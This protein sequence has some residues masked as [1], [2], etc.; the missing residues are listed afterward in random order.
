MEL[1]ARETGLIFF[2]FHCRRRRRCVLLL[3]HCLISSVIYE[4][5][6]W[7]MRRRDARA[8]AD[9]ALRRDAEAHTDL[10]SR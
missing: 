10:S 4:R 7:A 3:I 5:R 6:E 1:F 2:S 9:A 8:D